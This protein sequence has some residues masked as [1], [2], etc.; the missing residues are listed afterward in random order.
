MMWIILMVVLNPLKRITELK[1]SCPVT[2]KV[3]TAEYTSLSWLLI[4]E[5]NMD[6]GLQGMLLPTKIKINRLCL[7]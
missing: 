7:T 2:V 3:I 6:I 4:R 5:T 1:T